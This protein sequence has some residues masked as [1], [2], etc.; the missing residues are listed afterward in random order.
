[1]LMSAL[2]RVALLLVAF[3]YATQAWGPIGH[4]VVASIASNLLKPT[5]VTKILNIIGA[6]SMA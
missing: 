5:Q 4:E 1:M 3:A 6:S 2:W